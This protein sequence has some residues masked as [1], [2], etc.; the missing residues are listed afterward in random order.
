MYEWTVIFMPLTNTGLSPERVATPT[1][2]QVQGGE[3]AGVS[4][5]WGA[6]YATNSTNHLGVHKEKYFI[7]SVVIL[8]SGYNVV[9]IYHWFIWFIDNRSVQ[10]LDFQNNY[11]V[12][13]AVHLMGLLFLSV[14]V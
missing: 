10:N 4:I 1:S 3:P 14:K 7:L 9:L 8:D 2:A 5:H 13:L 12:F 11:N 6:L